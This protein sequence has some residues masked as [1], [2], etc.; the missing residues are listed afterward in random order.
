[1]EAHIKSSRLINAFPFFY[2]WVILA[3]GTTGIVM[4]GPSQSFTIALFL[5]FF[6]AESG[7]SRANLSLLYG[8][9]TL[10]GMLLLPLTGRLVDRVGARRLIFWVTIGFG[11]ACIGMSQVRGVAS[12]FVGLLMM[13]FWGLGSLQLGEQ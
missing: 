2:G 7:L 3:A 4:I 1:M 13:R 5:D 9:A 12:L 6:Q 8:I 10:G 11:L